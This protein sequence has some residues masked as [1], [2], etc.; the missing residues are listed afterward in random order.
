MESLKK[1]S[2]KGSSTVNFEEETKCSDQE[3]M[4]MHH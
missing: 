4:V 3:S 2:S 1:Q